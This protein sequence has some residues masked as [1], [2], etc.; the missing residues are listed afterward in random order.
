[1]KHGEDLALQSTATNGLEALHR[2]RTHQGPIDLLITEIDLPLMDG[3]E[4][5][6]HVRR[7]CPQVKVMFVVPETTAIRTSSASVAYIPKPFD[8]RTLLKKIHSLMSRGVE[9]MH[10]IA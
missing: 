9:R 3:G 6:A 4:L 7:L 5:A 8:T 10:A 1:V 2:A